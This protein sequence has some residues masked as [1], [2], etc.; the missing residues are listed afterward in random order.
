MVSSRQKVRESLLRLEERVKR[1]R[2]ARRNAPL[3]TQIELS[4]LLAICIVL[5]AIFL[6]GPTAP[7]HSLPVDLAVAS[8]S[9]PLPH[10]LAED[11]LIVGITRDGMVYFLNHRTTAK[12][13]TP[14]IKKALRDGAER[15]VYVKA[16]ARTR[17]SDVKVV[18]EAVQRAGVLDVVFLTQ[19]R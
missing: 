18:V 3:F 5:L 16:D 1:R 11:A 9:V 19:E 8:H 12:D 4:G 14:A 15:K 10:A 7:H 13:L 17:Y 2:L 6:V